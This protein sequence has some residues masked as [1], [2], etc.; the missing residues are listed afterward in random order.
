MS[1]LPSDPPKDAL[2]DPGLISVVIPAWNEAE[3]MR[4]LLQRVRDAIAPITREIEI[5]VIVPTPD[6]PTREAAEAGGARVLIQKRPGY[7]GAL[8]EGLLAARGNFVVTMDADLSHPPEAIP[9]ILEHRG[10]A[11]VII[12]S[13]YVT[14]ATAQLE[15]SRAFLSPLLNLIYRRI[16]AVPVMDMSSGFRVYHRKILD[17]LALECEKYDILEE[18]LVKAYSLGWKVLE[19]PFDYQLRVAGESHASVVSFTPH[20]LATLLRLWTMRNTYESADYDSRAFDSL[21]WPQRYWQRKRFQLVNELA[22]SAQPKLDI[23][24]GSSRIIQSEPETVGLDIEIAKLRFLRRT[25]PRLTCAD[26]VSLPFADHSFET[27]VN[28]QLIEHLPYDRRMFSEMNRIL[29]PGGTLVIGTPDYGRAAWRITEWFYKKLLPYGYGDEHLTR[30]TRY[31]LTEELAQA[32]FAIVSYRYV[33][34]GE[35]IVRC[36]KREEYVSADDG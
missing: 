17:E 18:I 35:L 10:E 1:T 33:L 32:G 27:V 11:E 12:G 14:G 13:R 29:K 25:N 7:G 4:D 28:S 34:G 16:L 3:T 21:V 22:G 6:D 30:Y 15:G 36:V 19:V 8:K 23:G 20:F 26:C 9:R 2:P 5:L 24:C 31:R